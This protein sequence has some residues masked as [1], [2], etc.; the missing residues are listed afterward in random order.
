MRIDDIKIVGKPL[1]RSTN[2]D[3]DRFE[4]EYWLTLPKGYREYITRLGEG[5]LGGSW[6]RIYP[7]SRIVRELDEWRD[8]VRQFWFWDAGR[9]LLPKSRALECVV[10]GDTMGGDELVFHPSRPN[11]LFVLPR[12]SEKIF[13]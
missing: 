8:R 3:V 13:E 11:R 10:I 9:K 4:S 2:A 7:R 12:E 6:V 1:V 5:I